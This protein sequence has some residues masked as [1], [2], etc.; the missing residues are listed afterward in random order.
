MALGVAVPGKTPD[1]VHL[2]SHRQAD[3]LNLLL[4]L[5][6]RILILLVWLFWLLRDSDIFFKIHS[7]AFSLL[8]MIA[9]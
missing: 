9:P 5:S 8:T 3:V 4:P 6:Q 2:R 1:N 7:C